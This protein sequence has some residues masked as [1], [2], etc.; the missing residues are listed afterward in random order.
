MGS[1][2][3]A[4]R[5]SHLAGQQAAETMESEFPVGLPV[6]HIHHRLRGKVV[7]YTGLKVVIELSKGGQTRFYATSL[8]PSACLPVPEAPQPKAPPNTSPCK[9]VF[10]GPL[11]SGLE[12][13]VDPKTLLV[14]STERVLR[15][16]PDLAEA[17]RA[18]EASLS[19]V[20]AAMSNA[21]VRKVW[22]R[23][24]SR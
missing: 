20:R 23:Q 16:R 18:E 9:I 2:R 21:V 1:Q 8:R 5:R 6:E 14:H 12:S 19:R 10:R 11:G 7:G 13:G 4:V 22:W 17:L 24:W 3:E 15:E